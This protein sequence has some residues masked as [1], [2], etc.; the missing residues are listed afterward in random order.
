[1]SKSWAKAEC[2]DR[3]SYEREIELDLMRHELKALRE[4]KATVENALDNIRKRPYWE[5]RIPYIRQLNKRLSEIKNEI[6]RLFDKFDL[7]G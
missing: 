3:T 7:E 6:E 1:M 2:F 5:D 4:E